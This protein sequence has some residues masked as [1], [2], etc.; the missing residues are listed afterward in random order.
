MSE[1]QPIET[2]PRKECLVYQPEHKSEG[3]RNTLAARICFSRDAGFY[4][5]ST[6][7][8]PLPDPP[9]RAKAQLLTE[10]AK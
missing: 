6:H 9:N 1:W 3:G 4:R 7:W 2:M 5:K 10:K 8:M